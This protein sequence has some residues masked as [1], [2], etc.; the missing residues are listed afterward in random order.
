MNAQI[1]NRG[2]FSSLGSGLFNRATNAYEQIASGD[3]YKKNDNHLRIIQAAVVTVSAAATGF[4]NAFAHVE[5]LGWPLAILLALLIVAFVERF[6]FVLRHGLTTVYQAGKQRFYATLCYRAIQITMV[7]NACLLT[8]WIVGIEP[9]PAL[10]WW[11][12]WSIAAHFALALIGVQAVRDSDAVIE[13]RMLE[14]KAATA[15][16]DIITLRK[17]AAIG[18]P[19]A[20][21]AARLRGYIDAA[22][23]SFRLLFSGG[24]FAKTFVDQINQ[25]A[26]EQYGHIDNLPGVHPSALPGS[27]T[28][29][30]PGFVRP[31]RSHGPKGPA[32]WI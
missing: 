25:V 22:V 32:R 12:H 15:R 2:Y 16:Q 28:R 20:L 24:N 13:N 26:A 30:G 1:L 11:N 27:Q 7:L 19:L 21:I 31:S 8:A 14:L 10:L 5:R 23:L 18:S 17:A 4:V 6:Y 29:P 9:P 3:D